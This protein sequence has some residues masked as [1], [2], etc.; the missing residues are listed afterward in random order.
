MEN[1]LRSLVI[2]V[3]VLASSVQT[4]AAATAVFA[5]SVYGTSGS[6]AGAS[7]ALGAADGASATILRVAGG[8]NLILQMSQ[9]T[10]GLNTLLSGA[11]L[12]LGSNVQI[13]IGE[14]IGGVAV[15]STNLTLPG[16]FGPTYALDLSALC[17]TVS[18]TGC[19][20][21]RIRVGGRPAPG[22]RWTAFR[23]SPRRRNP[24]PGR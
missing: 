8:S 4:A 1:A 11:R 20:L 13:A 12:T 18:S 17:T 14:V 23:A 19:S 21:L 5:T 3:I 6:V 7:N 16:G 10:S 15:F 22:S 2:A 24:R 9:A